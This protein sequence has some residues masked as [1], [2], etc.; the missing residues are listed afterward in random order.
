[1]NNTI[2]EMKTD[3]NIDSSEGMGDTCIGGC[4]YNDFKL[5]ESTIT[6]K[7]VK[8]TYKCEKCGKIRKQ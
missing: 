1:M 8:Y 6:E 7:A 4:K 3:I 2:I 5:I